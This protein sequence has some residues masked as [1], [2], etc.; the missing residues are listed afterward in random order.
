MSLFQGGACFVLFCKDQ[1]TQDEK[2]EMSVLGF[3]CSCVEKDLFQAGLVVVN[4]ANPMVGLTGA[5]GCGE[6]AMW[7]ARKFMICCV[8]GRDGGE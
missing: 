3:C 6:V 7:I 2:P 1:A 4:F 5:A 8:G